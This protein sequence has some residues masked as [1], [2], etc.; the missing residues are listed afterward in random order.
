MPQSS[1]EAT[2]ADRGKSWMLPEA[3]SEDL[4][5]VTN[6]SYASVYSYPKGLQIL[7]RLA[8]ALFAT[9]AAIVV[10]APALASDVGPGAAVATIRHDLPLLLAAQ[11]K[12]KP[13]KP[14]IDWIVTDGNDAVAMWSAEARRGVV[15]LRLRSGRWWWWAAAVKTISNAEAPWTL[16]RTPG[17]DLEDCDSVTVPNPPSAN[18]LLAEGYIGKALARELASRLPAIHTSN[19]GGGSDCDPDPQYLVSTT[20]ESE[21]TFTHRED[22]LPTWFTWI[23]Q[24][25]GDREGETGSSWTA[26]YSFTLT[27]RRDN[28]EEGM[29]RLVHST[30]KPLFDKLL[31]TPP[32]TL[33]F[34]RNSTIDVWL[35]YVLAQQDHYVL[36]I[37]NVT[38]D[39][40]GVPGTLK[41]NVLHFVL[42]AF[43]LHWEEVAHGEIYGSSADATGNATPSTHLQ[44]TGATA[45]TLAGVSLGDSLDAVIAAHSEAKQGRTSQGLILTWRRPEG[46]LTASLDATGRI[47]RID[48]SAD[49]SK[50]DSI[51]LP[52]IGQFPIQDSHVNLGVALEQSRCASVSGSDS[53]YELNDGSVVTV[54]FEGP[55]DGPLREAVWSGPGYQ[56]GSRLL[57]LAL[58]T[59]LLAACGGS[60]PPIGA[61]Q[62]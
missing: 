44:K 59:S 25:A 23:G 41:N 62:C 61:P 11:F 30:L 60:Q 43:T 32:P 19:I 2:R 5:Y 4:L 26:R 21:V 8:S 57:G 48:F 53:A 16:M 34:R 1:T 37:S 55:G 17:I 42:P 35:P 45:T 24:T 51:D 3:K 18:S 52:C 29:Q 56:A 14:T 36:R 12:D 40:D 49:D 27:A 31:P 38:P 39:I 54:T 20:G 47:T 13:T 15:N 6:Y 28:S 7:Q 9:A 58:T 33:A 10:Q 22:Y 46:T 50:D